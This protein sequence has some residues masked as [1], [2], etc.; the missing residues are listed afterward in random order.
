MTNVSM[1]P[2]PNLA[3]NPI[4]SHRYSCITIQIKNN[5]AKAELLELN[6]KVELYNPVILRTDPVIFRTNPVIIRTS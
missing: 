1:Q 2:R 5:K 3:P 4:K 6:M